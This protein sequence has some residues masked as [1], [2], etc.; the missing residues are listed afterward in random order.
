[1]LVAITLSAFCFSQD[2][3]PPVN[4]TASSTN[5]VDELIKTL[6]AELIVH[7]KN[8]N[9]DPSYWQIGYNSDTKE[10]IM[11]DID[12]ASQEIFNSYTFEPKFIKSINTYEESSHFSISIKAVTVAIEFEDALGDFELKDEFSMKMLEGTE[13]EINKIKQDLVTLLKTLGAPLSE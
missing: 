8:A 12:K 11:S 5:N 10:I 3:N 9:P 13:A 7:F 4:N 6:N 1:M 2:V